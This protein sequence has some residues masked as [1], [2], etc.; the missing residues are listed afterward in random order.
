MILSFA[1][2][3][4]WEDAQNEFRNMAKT[5][6]VKQNT[7]SDLEKMISATDQLIKIGI[8]KENGKA[9]PAKTYVQCEKVIEE[10]LANPGDF[11]HPPRL[12]GKLLSELKN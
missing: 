5:K 11:L 1:V 12:I 4:R 9:I 7:R 6:T 8:A 2:D 10:M 3:K